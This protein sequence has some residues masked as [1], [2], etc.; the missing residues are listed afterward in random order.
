MMV[1]RRGVIRCGRLAALAAL[2]L[3]ACLAGA[4]APRPGWTPREVEAQ[5]LCAAGQTSACGELGR[6]LVTHR[7]SERDFNRGMVLLEVT[8]A[9]NDAPSC[10]SLGEIYRGRDDDKALA[11]ATELLKRACELKSAEGCAALGVL[12]EAWERHDARPVLDAYRR[13]C[14]LGYARGC[15]FYGFAQRRQAPGVPGAGDPSFIAACGLGDLP[16]C[17]GLGRPRIAVAATRAEG[18]AY[19]LKACSGGFAP[20]CSTLT[21]LFAPVVGAAASCPQ[22]L[23][24]AARACAEGDENG[25][26]V[27]D[28][29]NIEAH[30]DPVAARGR[31][32]L[33]CE[34]GSSLACFYWANAAADPPAAP[35]EIKRAYG[36]A[37]SGRSAAQALACTRLAILKL[38]ATTDASETASLASSLKTACDRSIG[39][40]C[41]ALAELVEK[42]SWLPTDPPSSSEL[43]SKA[44]NLGAERCCRP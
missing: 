17:H 44:C 21:E 38:A 43:R 28:A 40:A 14:E 1:Q 36:L 27:A 9:N 39:E 25:C 16:S 13:S 4:P 29:C 6:G 24:V 32:G 18:I 33:A 12:S 2:I 10:L 5:R 15:A 8:C 37:C 31:L 42:R 41:C 34:Q 23:P 26:A 22:A 7:S 3:P 11:R 30:R 19:L 20:S 35:V